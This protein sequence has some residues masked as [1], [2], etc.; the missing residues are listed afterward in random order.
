M[1]KVIIFS[2]EVIFFFCE[3]VKRWALKPC[4]T[5]LIFSKHHENRFV[6]K[7]NAQNNVESRRAC[8]YCEILCS[9][10]AWFIRGTLHVWFHPGVNFTPRLSFPLSL[11]KVI[12]L[13]TCLTEV[14]SCSYYY[15]AIVLKTGAKLTPGIIQHDFNV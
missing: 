3:H 9:T 6:L 11:V 4:A 14:K 15:F 8:L 2:L 10:I 13:Y 5:F 12:F 1:V 7:S